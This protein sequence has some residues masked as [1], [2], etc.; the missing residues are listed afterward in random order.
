MNS[1]AA[2][3]LLKTLADMGN[4]IADS[5]VRIKALETALQKYE[6]NMYQCYLKA[7]DEESQAKATSG[8][9]PVSPAGVANLRSLLVRD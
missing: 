5:Q 4:A 1:L 3:M 6:P 8:Q 2:D 7:V 9:K